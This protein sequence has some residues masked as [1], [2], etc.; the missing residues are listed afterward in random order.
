MNI[1]ANFSSEQMDDPGLL[2][3]VPMAMSDS[4]EDNLVLFYDSL[5]YVYLTS[6]YARTTCDRAQE[7]ARRPARPDSPVSRSLFLHIIL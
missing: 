4:E 5:S 3:F 2:D 6:V 1:T 7:D